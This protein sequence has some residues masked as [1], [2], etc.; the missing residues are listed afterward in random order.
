MFP[1]ALLTQTL[2]A[3]QA[4]II[5]ISLV[6][7]VR[8]VS[9]LHRLQHS[10]DDHGRAESG[11]QTEEKHPA[12]LI[13]AQGLQSCVVNHFDGT[14]EGLGKVKAHPA[15]SQV[16]GFAKRP[17]I[18]NRGR[19]SEGNA[20]E[21]PCTHDFSYYLDHPLGGHRRAGGDLD[22]HRLP[23]GQQLDV[24]A[25]NIN[26]KHFRRS[27]FGQC[28]HQVPSSSVQFFQVKSGLL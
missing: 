27:S 19:V 21:V 13:A 10:I 1:P 7:L 6:V 28:F 15:I 14:S 18:D 9:Q 24:R 26:Y 3:A 11:P 8:Q 16:V 17:P 5:L 25:A 12:A 22:G 23:H 20:L 2:Q 4:Q